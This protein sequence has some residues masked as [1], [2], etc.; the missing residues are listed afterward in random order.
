MPPIK[1]KEVW[2]KIA[3]TTYQKRSK[4]QSPSGDIFQASHKIRAEVCGGK[5]P[6][7][8]DR[9]LQQL[10]HMRALRKHVAWMRLG[11]HVLGD[12]DEALRLGPHKVVKDVGNHEA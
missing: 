4:Q 3:S 11:R 5:V 6:E 12:G 2:N 9:E 1:Q 10:Q 7:T 8:K